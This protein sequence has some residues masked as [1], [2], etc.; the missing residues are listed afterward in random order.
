VGSSYAHKEN[1]WMGFDGEK[2]IEEKGR[3][4]RKFGGLM[5]DSLDRDYTQENPFPHAEQLISAF[6]SIG[7]KTKVESQRVEPD[8]AVE[9]VGPESHSEIYCAEQMTTET[10]NHDAVKST[11]KPGTESFQPVEPV[12]EPRQLTSMQK[13]KFCIAEMMTFKKQ[14]KPAVSSA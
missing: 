13:V 14:K 1:K 4:A 2:D 11:V 3:F 6:R 12:V 10:E 9:T 7:Q 8:C 5:I